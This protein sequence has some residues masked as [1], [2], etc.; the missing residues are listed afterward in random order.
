[1]NTTTH[2]MMMTIAFCMTLVMS[3]TACSDNVNGSSED[4]TEYTLPQKIAIIDAGS[5]G[6]RL[7]VYEIK[8]DSTIKI[9][10]PTTEDEKTKSKGRALSTIVNHTD[11]VKKYIE[12]MTTN[13]SHVTSS[14]T[15]PLYI[16]ATAGMRNQNKD[17]ADGIYS[18]MTSIQEDINGFKVQKATTIS[19]RYEGLYAWIAANYENNTLTTSSKGILEIGGA[20]MQVAFA[21]NS[22]T[23]PID[24]K[25]TRKNWGTL[26]CKSYLQGGIDAI[27][28]QT[29]D[30]IPFKFT[31]PIEDISAYS[32]NTSFFGCS[33]GVRKILIGIEKEGSTD[34]YAQ[35]LPRRDRY[36]NFMCTYYLQWVLENLH[37]TN[38]IIADP[39]D[40]DWTEGA[41][42]DIIINKEA[43]EVFDYTKKL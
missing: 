6:S 28:A 30:T 35:T 12:Q 14:E 11:S 31:L 29:P 25:I 21:T 34:A 9:I 3:I 32:S 33:T 4:N 41:A 42:Y 15:I 26:Y 2:K 5:T 10:Y 17:I 22:T 20:S 40:S 13:Y 7:K 27:Y 23:V 18:K 37:L 1:M 36:H 16:L 43:P 38:R 19:G 39:Y 8:T 24:Y